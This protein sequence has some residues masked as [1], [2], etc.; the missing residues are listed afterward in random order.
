MSDTLTHDVLSG[1]ES[2][3]Y[4]MVALKDYRDEDYLKMSL[5]DELEY[6]ISELLLLDP[7]IHRQIRDWARAMCRAIGGYET[8]DEIETYILTARMEAKEDPDDA[9][10]MVVGTEADLVGLLERNERTA[11][12]LTE[13]ADLDL[14]RERIDILAG[15][16]ARNKGLSASDETRARLFRKIFFSYKLWEA[17][18]GQVGYYNGSLELQSNLQDD[19]EYWMYLIQM[20]L[21]KPTR[22]FLFAAPKSM[23]AYK[24]EPKTLMPWNNQFS[25]SLGFHEFGDGEIPRYAMGRIE[26]VLVEVVCDDKRWRKL[27]GLLGWDASD[28]ALKSERGAIIAHFGRKTGD[29]FTIPTYVDLKALADDL[30]VDGRSMKAAG[31]AQQ[32]TVQNCLISLRGEVDKKAF[33][34]LVLELPWSDEFLALRYNAFD[35]LLNH[36]TPQQR[37]GARRALRI[38]EG[39]A[40]KDPRLKIDEIGTDYYDPIRRLAQAR[41]IFNVVGRKA[42]ILVEPSTAMRAFK[43]KLERLSHEELVALYANIDDLKHHVSV[44]KVGKQAQ[45]RAEAWLERALLWRK[46]IYTGP[47]GHAL[48]YIS[49][50]ARSRES[51]VNLGTLLPPD[52]PTLEEARLVVIA[53][54]IGRNQH[55]SYDE[56][57]T[58]ACGV[59]L[60]VP[61][62]QGRLNYWHHGGYRDL[63]SINRRDDHPIAVRIRA[64]AK[65][66]AINAI[67]NYKQQARNGKPKDKFIQWVRQWHRDATGIYLSNQQVDSI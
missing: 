50:Y 36:G 20:K 37:N 9:N 19:F 15:F 25:F 34:T 30:Q 58:G 47:S 35:H 18:L 23:M 17:L 3:S 26:S 62:A 48:T 59:T 46:P 54:L 28:E 16:R 52:L 2:G 13:G 66:I 60:N 67:K 4:I 56:V 6:A 7:V 39:P 57:M 43:T 5:N 44:Y 42:N 33:F 40:I 24:T 22:Q 12:R 32:I 10:S 11:Y 55:H 45:E 61:G 31:L 49:L 53:G 38:G 1:A 63:L 21:R 51:A 14:I 8:V 41:D 27:L 65:A 64:A 29:G